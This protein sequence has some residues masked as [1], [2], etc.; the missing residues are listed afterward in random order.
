METRTAQGPQV[1]RDRVRLE[2]DGVM[3]VEGVDFNVDR[4]AGVLQLLID[5]PIGA[6]GSLHRFANKMDLNVAKKA[7][8]PKKI[9]QWKRR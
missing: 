8:K 4:Q 9:A 1:T 5:S 6:K 3:Y 2:V 7:K